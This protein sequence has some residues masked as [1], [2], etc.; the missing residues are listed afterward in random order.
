[1]AQ[2]NQTQQYV[3]LPIRGLRANNRTASPETRSF[4][5]DAFGQYNAGIAKKSSVFSAGIA[6]T[7]T[8]PES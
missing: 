7:S 8:V 2:Q 5:L 6:L 1:M 3:L 4:L